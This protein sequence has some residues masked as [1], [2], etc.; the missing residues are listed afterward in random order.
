METPARMRAILVSK[1][2]KSAPLSMSALSAFMV[3]TS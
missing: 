3:P 1:N 2:V